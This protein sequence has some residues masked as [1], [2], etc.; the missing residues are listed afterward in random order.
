DDWPTQTWWL[1]ARV[2]VVAPE[3]GNLRAALEWSRTEPADVQLRLVIGMAPL[4]MAQGRFAE[5]ANALQGALNRGPEPTMLR[6]RAL[7]RRGWLAADPG[8]LP[9]AAAAAQEMLGLSEPAGGRGRAM[10]L[11]LEGYV[12]M[13]AGDF[14]RAS[15]S[16][17][18]SLI[19]YQAAGDLVGVA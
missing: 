4:W 8:D 3:L 13:Q 7:E 9:S 19:G 18:E 12:A 16:L 6:L 1:D 14:A 11:A 10:A 5:G 17:G 15:D 2:Q